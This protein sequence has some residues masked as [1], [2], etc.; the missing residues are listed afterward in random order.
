MKAVL[1][2]GVDVFIEMNAHPILGLSVKEAI[3]EGI[4]VAALRRERSAWDVTLEALAET[5]VGGVDLNWQE[6]W[7]GTRANYVR[8]PAY[9]WQ[10]ERYWIE[11]RSR[12][13]SESGHSLFMTRVQSSEIGR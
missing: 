12:V 6:V 7:N 10:R 9:P 5:Y 3:H 2:E 4:V 8:L 13:A 11:P 1:D